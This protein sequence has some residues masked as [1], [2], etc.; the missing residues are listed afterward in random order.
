MIAWLGNGTKTSVT[1]LRSVGNEVDRH[2]GSL[3]SICQQWKHCDSWPFRSWK[4]LPFCPQ[5]G[6]EEEQGRVGERAKW[7]AESVGDMA[8]AE[9]SF[10]RELNKFPLPFP[11][12]HLCHF[13]HFC[14]S[15][16]VFEPKVVCQKAEWQE[17]WL[18]AQTFA[19]RAEALRRYRHHICPGRGSGSIWNCIKSLCLF[20]LKKISIKLAPRRSS[21]RQP[22]S[23]ALP[24]PYACSLPMLLMPILSASS[25][26]YFPF[27]APTWLAR[28]KKS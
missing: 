2:E 21:K 20:V 19:K 18:G 26:L 24:Y 23:A 11:I 9:E 4:Q 28:Q 8:R 12:F 15:S 22:T 1:V 3:S 16:F 14:S 10:G 7:A 27:P 25:R 5:R 13:C 6:R 17:R